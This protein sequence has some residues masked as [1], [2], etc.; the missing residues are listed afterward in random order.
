[1]GVVKG[2][3]YKILDPRGVVGVRQGHSRIDI[4]WTKDDSKFRADMLKYIGK[5]IT[6]PRTSDCIEAF[7][8]YWHPWMLEEVTPSNI[9]RLLRHVKDL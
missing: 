4:Y 1:M 5:T 7:N 8:W 3:V 6:A 2:K 9:K